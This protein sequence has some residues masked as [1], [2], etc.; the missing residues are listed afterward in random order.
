M[1]Y[2]RSNEELIKR[3]EE[4]LKHLE[5]DL[6]H[7]KSDLSYAGRVAVELRV[8]VV[9][10]NTNI[11]LLL[12]LA[13]QYGYELSYSIDAP[14]HMASSANLLDTL[15]SDYQVKYEGKVITKVI[16]LIKTIADK[17]GA[18][19]DLEYSN[20]HLD[21]KSEEFNIGGYPAYIYQLL[22]IGHTVLR[23]GKEFVANA[24]TV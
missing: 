9:K 2:S 7:L 4:R 5:I 16:E 23:V 20:S 11:P 15:N 21:A 18:H 17:E 13:E 6:N 14:P 10:T 22:V 8:L 1:S 24:K 3:L 12:Y 19:E